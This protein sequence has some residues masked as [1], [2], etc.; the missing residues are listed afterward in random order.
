MMTDPV[1]SYLSLPYRFSLTPDSD[2]EGNAGW[3]A[4]VDEL[5]GC[6]SQGSSPDEAVERVRDA[7]AGWISV[8][9]ED[10]RPIPPPRVTMAYSGRFLVRIP[11]SLHAALAHHAREEGVS[12][13][14][15][16]SSALAWAI[17]RRETREQVPA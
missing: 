7:M 3:V 13:N 1:E 15:F 11:K 14:L 4:E 6:V 17:G 12:L 9:L 5:P 10:G 2:D 16:V 8:A